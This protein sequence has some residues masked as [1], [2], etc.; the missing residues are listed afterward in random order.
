[1]ANNTDLVT[2]GAPAEQ[3][4]SVKEADGTV[5]TAAGATLDGFTSLKVDAAGWTPT[6]ALN[7]G[8]PYK[9]WRGDTLL[10]GSVDP[11]ADFT[12]PIISQTAIAEKIKYGNSSGTG[13]NVSSSFGSEGNDDLYTVVVD[14]LWNDADGK[15]TR[16][17]RYVYPKCSVNEV[18]LGAH[19]RTGVIID[20]VT[21]RPLADE[22]H[23]YMYHYTAAA[24]GAESSAEPGTGE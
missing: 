19:T 18:A 12:I 23:Q 15:P 10:D 20:N 16:A 9:D 8:E 14:E 17:S 6:A 7:R 1:M 21:F 5:P 24:A 3:Y 13:E 4:F 22:N 2:Y 11:S